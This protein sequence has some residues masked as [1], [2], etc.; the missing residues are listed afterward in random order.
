M[1]NWNKN[2][3]RKIIILIL[4]FSSCLYFSQRKILDSIKIQVQAHSNPDTARAFY[5]N[6][7]A[8]QYLDFSLDSSELY[9]KEGLGLS[10][11][12]NYISG[13]ISAKNVKGLM[14]R[15]SNNPDEA[16]KVGEEVIQLR[17]TYGPASKLT[18]AYTNLGSV[19]IVKGDYARALKYLNKGLENAQKWNQVE[20]Q[21]LILSNIGIVYNYSELND[22]ALET[23]QKAVVINKQLS[24][25][26][27]IVQQA[28]LYTNIA[29]IY[30][31]RG[32]YNEAYKYFKYSYDVYKKEEDTRDLS[33]V[34]FNLTSTTRNN[35]DLKGCEF[36]LKEMEKISKVLNQTEY[37]ASY[38]STLANYLLFTGKYNEA[39]TK[40]NKGLELVDTINSVQLYGVLLGIKSDYYKYTKDYK[41]A[42]E[43][44]DRSLAVIK[45]TSNKSEIATLY[46][47]KS[48]I[49]KALNDHKTAL[50]FFEK[51]VLLRDSINNEKFDTRMVTLNS[52]NQLDKKERE[53]ALLNSENE[54]VSIENKRQTILLIAGSIVGVLVFVLLIF[55]LRAYRIKQ[56]DN[57]LLNEQKKEIKHQ[58]DIVDEKQKE[59]V[60][61]IN[62]AQQIQKTLIANHEMVNQTIPDSFVFFKPK[63]IV[64]GDF[65]WATK[66][67]NRFYLAV[68]DSTGHGVPGAFMSLLNISFLN[69]AIKE[70]EL[71][72]PNQVF[73]HVRKRLIETIS[74]N[75]R[76]DGMDGILIC[77]EEGSNKITYA[78]ANNKPVLIADNKLVELS[79]DKMPVGIGEKIQAFTEFSFE[80]KKGDMVYLYTDGLPD[81]FGGP[82]GKKFKYKQ[83]EEVLLENNTMDVYKQ[84]VILK[85]KFESWMGVL[86][87]VDD[88]CVLGFRLYTKESVYPGAEVM[89]N[90]EKENNIDYG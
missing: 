29:A 28:Q 54:K 34:V 62:Y 60:D 89:L 18:G 11:K 85:R 84:E 59:I 52:F 25:D 35:K 36:F 64:S 32:L 40:I 47:A 90:L 4:I 21:I 10:E 43:Y 49:Y 22:L 55:S 51:S 20:N 73:D 41:K 83:L 30:D 74:Q 42:L 76:R 70:K 67:G 37:T 53:L 2:I 3:M 14:L 82:K 1:R 16:I 26:V 27:Q 12:L 66:K 57:L 8:W 15:M 71:T 88:V 33:I 31:K 61:S 79:C 72:K 45:K 77:I 44:T 87:Q 68:C 63:D 75:G 46:M 24:G 17:Q 13:I 65:Y 56:K 9:Y 19:Y 48:Q 5:L 23:F 69:E 58:K 7:L 39:I 86:E 78:A 80:G 50:V 38:Y 81:Q 6:E